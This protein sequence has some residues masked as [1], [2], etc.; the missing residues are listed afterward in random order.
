MPSKLQMDDSKREAPAQNGFQ[1]WKK[2]TDNRFHIAIG[3]I[4]SEV[5]GFM[6]NALE[7]LWLC[8]D[9]A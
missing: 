9:L 8:R 3:D 6:L 4:V 5:C 1:H 2:T 7:G